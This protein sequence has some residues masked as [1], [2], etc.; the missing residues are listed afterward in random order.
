MAAGYHFTVKLS[1]VFKSYF[2]STRVACAT[3]VKRLTRFLAR[4]WLAA[5]QKL[6]HVRMSWNVTYV[7]TRPRVIPLAND[8]KKIA[9]MPFR[10]PLSMGMG[11]HSCGPRPQRSSATIFGGGTAAKWVVPT[12]F[13]AEPTTKMKSSKANLVTW[14]FRLPPKRQLSILLQCDYLDRATWKKIDQSQRQLRTKDS[15][16]FS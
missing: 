7:R 1:T 9:S 4:H 11:L 3:P 8:H 12:E 5:A 16:V 6:L 10:T 15:K 13:A 2:T 14:T